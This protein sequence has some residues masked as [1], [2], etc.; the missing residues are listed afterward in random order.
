MKHSNKIEIKQLVASVVSCGDC[1]GFSREA[2]LPNST[3]SCTKQGAIA[4]QTICPH[5]RANAFNLSDSMKEGTE[6]RDLLDLINKVPDESLKAVAG[7][8]LKEAKSRSLGARLGMRVYVRYR[9]RDKA[10]YASNFLAARVL[11]ISKERIR[12]ISDDGMTCLTFPN[13]GFDGPIYSEKAFAPIR[14]AIRKQKTAYD[15]EIEAAAER[16][17]NRRRLEGIFGDEDHTRFKTPNDLSLD[18]LEIAELST[19]ARKKKK[20]RRTSTLLDLAHIIEQGN[21]IGVSSDAAGVSRLRDNNYGGRLIRD[22]RKTP[23]VQALDDM[24]D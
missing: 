21:V 24:E 19:V 18:N 4:S 14:K 12:L 23:R 10:D 7:L 22:G 3:A 13:T 1:S 2:L 9:G 17:S 5:F 15:P 11:D 6:V 20:S 16:E 8:L